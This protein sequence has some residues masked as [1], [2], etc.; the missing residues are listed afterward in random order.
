MWPLETL[1]KYRGYKEIENAVM[2]HFPLKMRK[3]V[4]KGRD[5]P[6][7]SSVMM[8]KRLGSVPKAPSRRQHK[9][10]PSY[11]GLEMPDELSLQL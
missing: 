1:E 9:G 3:D 5:N 2:K 4:S 8:G 6:P 7:C 10:N 11:S